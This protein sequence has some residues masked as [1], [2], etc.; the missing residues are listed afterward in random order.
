MTHRLSI[1]WLYSMT[2]LLVL[3]PVS[4]Q[5]LAQHG[6]GG[7]GGAPGGAPGGGMGQGGA[8]GGMTPAVSGQPG[9]PAGRGEAQGAMRGQS[10]SGPGGMQP[11][12]SIRSGPV[13]A[14]PGRF[15][16]DNNLVHTL[17]LRPDQ[18]RR[19]DAIFD[20]N[21]PTLQS[22]FTNLQREEAKLSSL[23]PRKDQDQTKIF[24]AIDRVA[25]ARADLEKEKQLLNSALRKEMDPQQVQQLEQISTAH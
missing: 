20:A 24:A 1:R 6:G 13:A 25:Q 12:P 14:I 2:L 5:A 8:R 16:D 4:R 19:M 23:S 18:Q 15:W 22:L 21:R 10:N 11:A 7:P 17:R 3:A 9:E